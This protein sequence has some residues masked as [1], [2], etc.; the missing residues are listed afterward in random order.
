MTSV[1]YCLQCH[2]LESNAPLPY[3]LGPH[4]LVQF[5]VNPDIR[6]AHLLLCELPDCCNGSRGAS[7][8]PTEQRST[9]H[10][11]YMTVVRVC[12]LHKACPMWST[13]PGGCAASHHF[14]HDTHSD[15]S[16][17]PRIV[18]CYS[19]VPLKRTH[20]PWMYLCR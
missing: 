2:D 14:S 19:P 16:C 3:S 9:D 13:C 6:S 12:V 18:R 1:V 20:T 5:G 7:L 11:H 8:E 15:I 17:Y 4:L 10:T